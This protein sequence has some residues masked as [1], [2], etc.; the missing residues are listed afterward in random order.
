M[1]RTIL[2]D[3]LWSKLLTILLQNGLYAKE[4]MRLTVEGILYRI[5]AG[6]PW[7]DLP[8]YFGKYNTVYRAFNRWS[9][10]GIPQ[11]IL[12][13]LSK[14]ADCEWVFIDASYI[15]AHQHAHGAA[16]ENDEAIGMSRGGNTSKIHM[17]ADS[18]GNPLYFE[19]SAGNVADVTMAGALLE[20]IDLTHCEVLSADKGY[21][22]DALRTEI[23][24]HNVKANIPYRE[25]RK[26]KNVKMDWFLYGTRHLIENTFARL[27]HFRA[28]ATRYD[29]LKR[30]YH[31]SVTWACIVIWLPL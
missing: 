4:S 13:E 3:E 31:S 26:E 7:R 1:P 23:E 25:S 27:K 29:K 6:C 20:H 12:Q 14:E 17:S 2:T 5:R 9:D 21:D 24:Q 8:R 19:L 15:K 30:H 10:K 22:S 28:I 16:G 11:L 18:N